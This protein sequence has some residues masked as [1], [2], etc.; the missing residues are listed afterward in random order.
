MK[1]TSPMTTACRRV[2][3][4]GGPASAVAKLRPRRAG[5]SDACGSAFTRRAYQSVQPTVAARDEGEQDKSQPYAVGDGTPALEDGMPVW[6]GL[7]VSSTA[8]MSD[9]DD[10]YRDEA[11][12]A[13]RDHQRNHDAIETQAL[14]APALDRCEDAERERE[15]RDERAPPGNR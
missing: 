6:K 11:V 5:P 8:S 2:K 9:G 3:G 4:S 1:N 12:V 13:Q 7:M 15:D 14:V 10:R